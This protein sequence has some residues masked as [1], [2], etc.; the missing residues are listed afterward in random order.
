MK[1]RSSFLL[2]L[3]LAVFPIVSFAQ[4]NAGSRPQPILVTPGNDLSG[5]MADLNALFKADEEDETEKLPT[6]P[7]IAPEKNVK[8]DYV[9]TPPPMPETIPTLEREAFELI[10]ARR[11]ADGLPQLTWSDEVAKVARAHSQN[12][13]GYKFFSHQGLDGLMVNGRADQVGLNKWRSIGENIAFMRGYEHPAEF[14]VECWMES[15][16][17]R[18]NLLRADWKESAIGVAQASDGS[19]YFT[20][21]F[22]IRR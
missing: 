6:R 5:M 17:H 2:I 7:R 1:L 15:A 11:A 12:M 19:Y 21:V 20:Q 14:A 10:N 8:R 18:S 22:L 3:L 4:N 9:Y 16:S 13:A